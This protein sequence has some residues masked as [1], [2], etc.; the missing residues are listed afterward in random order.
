MR[1]YPLVT[2]L[3]T[4]LNRV[5]FLEKAINSVLEQDYPNIEHLIID[6]GSTDGTVDLLKKYE[7]RYTNKGYVVHWISEKDSGQAEAEN[8]G[9]RLAKG[10]FITILNSD[11]YLKKNGITKLIEVF[12]MNPSIDIVYGD[13]ESI[14]EGENKKISHF[15]KYTL[16]DIVYKG[17]YIPQAG[18]MFKKELIDEVGMLDE[19]FHHAFEQDFFIR[20]LK[21]G[22]K[23][24]H[25]NEVVETMLD[26]SKRMTHVNFKRT[27]KEAKI[28]Y[29]RHGGKYLS[30]FYLLY[31]KS[32]YLKNFF[33]V[34]RKFFPSFYSFAKNIFYK[35]T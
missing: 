19:S 18:C 20:C 31:F 4:S 3:T 13:H 26:H 1:N 16:E 2:I 22:V 10:K 34:L 7:E 25:L 14:S 6:G 17:Y 24:Y 12:L 35:I 28:V 27:M 9:F 15:R 11:D 32:R 8:K 5:I 21:R 30:R 33:D 29:F 23:V